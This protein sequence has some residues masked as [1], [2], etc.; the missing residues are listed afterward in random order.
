[1]VL[2]LARAGIGAGSARSDLDIEMSGRAAGTV[3]GAG[4]ALACLEAGV[5]EHGA[6]REGTGLPDFLRR[7][8]ACR[9]AVI[10]GERVL[11]GAED[12]RIGAVPLPLEHHPLQPAGSLVHLEIDGEVVAADLLALERDIDIAVSELDRGGE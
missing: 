5:V 9:G 8:A 12:A 3:E 7:P 4:A 2:L 6:D 11:H 10:G 1:M